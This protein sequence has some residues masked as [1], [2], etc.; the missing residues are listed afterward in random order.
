MLFIVS[1]NSL[2]VKFDI[3]ILLLLWR[4]KH[5]CKEDFDVETVK[6]DILLNGQK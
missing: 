5:K 4:E 2:F 3:G 6:Q 1:S